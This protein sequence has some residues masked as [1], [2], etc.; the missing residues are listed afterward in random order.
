[1]LDVKSSF[2]SNP[3]KKIDFANDKVEKTPKYTLLKGVQGLN[4]TN[5]KSVRSSN[6]NSFINRSSNFRLAKNT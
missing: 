1:M 6:S 3:N 5:L 2:L 4:M